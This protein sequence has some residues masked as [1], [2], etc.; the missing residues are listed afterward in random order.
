MSQQ[1]EK[2]PV[3]GIHAVGEEQHAIHRDGSGAGACLA[4]R[5]I[6]LSRG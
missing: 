4:G 1:R 3:R 2:L 6:R 5:G